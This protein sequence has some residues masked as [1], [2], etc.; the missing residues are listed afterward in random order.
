[1][2]QLKIYNTLTEKKEIFQPIDESNI[3]MYVCG[4]TVYA[5][6]HL[7]NARSVVVYDV[8]YRILQK[9]FP[10]VT[11]LRNI[12]DVD[13]KIIK[14]AQNENTTTTQIATRYANF[15]HEDMEYLNCLSPS[16][17]PKATNYINDMIDLIKKLIEKKKAYIKN[18]SVYFDVSEFAEYGKLSKRN[19]KEQINSV[20]I[21]KNDEKEDAEDF[22]LWKVEKNE[23]DAIFESPWGRGRPGW[24]IECSAMIFA[25]FGDTFDIH[26]G[27]S[28][29]KF[30]HHE[31]EIAQV[32]GAYPDAHYAKYWVHNGFLTV[33]GQKMSKS[34]QNFITVS[35]IREKNLDGEIVRYA[36]LRTHYTQ[37]F[38]WSEDSI[39]NAKRDLKKLCDTLILFPEL[40][41]DEN[42]NDLN[43]YDK[44]FENLLDDMNTSSALMSLQTLA[45]QI[46][47]E[48][49]KKIQYELA[50]KIYNSLKF[51]GIDL[52]AL[53]KKYLSAIDENLISQLIEERKIAKNKKDFKKADEIRNKL[54]DLGI[55]IKDLKD[56]SVSW[57]QTIRFS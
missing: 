36:M 12:T 47:I 56:G 16:F 6:A 17:E 55:E 1:M 8:L 20:R 51:I 57:F 7:G 50:S 9:I 42:L 28:D 25:N 3:K 32:C 46:H 33:E 14:A 19:V 53:I 21:A 37:P 4:P 29:L 35:D 11:Y 39:L 10:K 23:T 48:N 41:N 54:I 13:D 38:D 27:G 34:L 22:V 45:N 43:L 26:G 2:M 52:F 44:F 40:Q 18:D 49:D 30:P 15:F 31:N 5:R 24:H